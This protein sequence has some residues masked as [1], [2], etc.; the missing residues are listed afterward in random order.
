MLEYLK[1]SALVEEHLFLIPSEIWPTLAEQ[2]EL[3][4]KNVKKD[5][6]SDEELMGHA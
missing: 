1:T 4:T 6:D 5:K 2:F 3:A